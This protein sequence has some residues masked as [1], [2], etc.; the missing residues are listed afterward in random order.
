M[1]KNAY[2][3]SANPSK[4]SKQISSFFL[5]LHRT[6]A[7]FFTYYELNLIKM[8]LFS[9]NIYSAFVILRFVTLQVNRLAYKTFLK[10]KFQVIANRHL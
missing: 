2:K 10:I 4:L 3:F 7:F 9:S 8:Y 6:F 5:H 1:G